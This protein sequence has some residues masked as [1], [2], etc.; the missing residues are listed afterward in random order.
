MASNESPAK[1]TILDAETFETLHSWRMNQATVATNARVRVI[2]QLLFSKNGEELIAVTGL[3]NVSRM[4]TASGELLLNFTHPNGFGLVHFDQARGEIVSGGSYASTTLR[5][6]DAETG[7]VKRTSGG[8]AI[9]TCLSG[10]NRDNNRLAVGAA[11]GTISL[12]HPEHGEMTTL[13]GAGNAGS[14]TAEL[15]DVIGGA[16]FSPN[17]MTIATLDWNGTCRLWDCTPLRQ[18][19]AARQTAGR[20]RMYLRD[21]R[22]LVD[23][24]FE[25]HILT[26]DVVEALTQAQLESDLQEAAVNVARM[27]GDDAERLNTDALTILLDGKRRPVD[28]VRALAA[29]EKAWRIRNAPA[30]RVTLGAAHFRMGDDA[31]AAETLNSMVNVELDPLDAVTRDLFRALLHR[32]QDEPLKARRVFRSADTELRALHALRPDTAGLAERQLFNEEVRSI[33]DAR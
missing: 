20:R 9:M 28:Y 30:Y 25:K 21:A 18:Q 8:H 29:A 3:E 32:V 15:N 6:H 11:D 1:I 27:H 10:Y 22:I 4:N 14:G 19:E 24:L 7:E 33:T 16:T 17:G 2:V 13:S 23:R 26:A 31:R 12:W 5:F